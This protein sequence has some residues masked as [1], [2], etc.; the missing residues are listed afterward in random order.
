MYIL[1]LGS[2]GCGDGSLICS[3]LISGTTTSLKRITGIDIS[4]SAITKAGN[5]VQRLVTGSNVMSFANQERLRANGTA[6][7]GVSGLNSEEVAATES[8]PGAVDCHGSQ[9][10]GLTTGRGE[11]E[12]IEGSDAAGGSAAAAYGSPANWSPSV[13]LIQADVTLPQY[14]LPQG[15][16]SLAGCDLVAC[17]EV[18]EHL[19]PESL[20]LL[21]PTLLGGLQPKR[22]VFTTPNWEYNKVLRELGGQG[23]VMQGPPG[24]DGH[25]LR[26]GDHK[27]EWTRQEFRNWAGG[28][29]AAYGY[30]VVFEDVGRALREVEVM[31][32]GGEELGGASQAAV[33]R[34]VERGSP[35]TDYRLQG[36]G[37]RGA[38][39]RWGRWCGGQGRWWWRWE[40]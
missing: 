31:E 15:W 14:T 17:I 32:G 2:A 5:K 16:G 25:P 27:F 24:R 12:G 4:P 28:L 29:A 35:D 19:H 7:A 21:G 8:G 18:L 40:G 33:F 23:E 38:G 3:L 30:D 37:G 1:T 9:S 10:K 39:G 36:A 26:H 6:A 13:T 22:A 34:R 20:A 11:M